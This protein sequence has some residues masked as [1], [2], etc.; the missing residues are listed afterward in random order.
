MQVDGGTPGGATRHQRVASAVRRSPTLVERL[1]ALRWP[2]VATHLPLVTN[3]WL[4]LIGGRPP[5]VER[6]LAIRWPGVATHLPLVTSEWLVLVLRWPPISNWERVCHCLA[7][8]HIQRKDLMAIAWL[9]SCT[10]A[11][12]IAQSPAHY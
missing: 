1:L 12:P 11:L 3:E 9:R 10:D 4:V 6:L 8:V 2:S 7:T 5:L